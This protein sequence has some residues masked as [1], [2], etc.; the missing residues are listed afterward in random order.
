MKNRHE[1]KPS[2][3]V[4][5]GGNSNRE[6]LGLFSLCEWRFVYSAFKWCLLFGGIEVHVKRF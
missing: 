2:A 5:D 1:S 4:P 3:A 6:I